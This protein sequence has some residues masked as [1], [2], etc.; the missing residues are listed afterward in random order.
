MQ[1]G[2]SGHT[3]MWRNV[4][5]RLALIADVTPTV[6]DDR[7]RALVDVWLGD[8]HQGPLPVSGPQVLQVH[9]GGWHTA[10]LR[11]TVAPAFVQHLEQRIRAAVAAGAHLITPSDSA[12]RE[13]QEMFSVESERVHPVHHGVDASLFRPDLGGGAA[14]VARA[15]GRSGVPYVLYVGV[16]HPRKNIGALREAMVALAGRG[17]EHQLVLVAGPPRDRPD[18]AAMVQ[19]AARDLPGVPAPSN[20]VVL[21]APPSN[22]QLAAIMAGASALCLPSLTEGFGLPVLEAMACGTPVVASNRGALPEVVGEAGVL[23]EPTAAG[24]EQGLT[25]VLADSR[26]ARELGSAGRQRAVQHSWERTAS[27]WLDALRV[28]ASK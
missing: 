4:I 18:G 9:E 26:L 27:G 12:A 11:A 6:I 24:V 14:L 20:R 17:F 8:G 25:R 21:I 28:A 10:E 7:R 2:G 13:V 22:A 16:A 23:V 3:N 15:G 19:A 1:E 5:A